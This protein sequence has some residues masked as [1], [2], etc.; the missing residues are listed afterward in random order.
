MR[1]IIKDDTRRQIHATV[2]A[3][4]ERKSATPRRH[5]EDTHSVLRLIRP[6]CFLSQLNTTQKTQ[7]S[8]QFQEMV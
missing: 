7:R 6:D 8:V 2:H 1:D 3:L 4:R 5:R